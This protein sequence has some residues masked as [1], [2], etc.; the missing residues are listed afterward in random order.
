MWLF[1]LAE[2]ALARGDLITARRFADEAV[3]TTRG[4]HMTLAYRTRAR[5]ALAQRE[6]EQAESDAHAALECAADFEAYLGLA[7]IMECLGRLAAEADNNP[8]AAR[9]LAAADSMRRRNGEVR[10]KAYDADYESTVATLRNALSDEDF[11]SVWAEGAALSTEEAI[12][13]AQRGRG[14]RKRPSTG[15]ASLTPTE[16]DVARLV[17]EGLGNKDIAARLFVSHRT[18]QT[19]LT[20]VYTKLGMTSRVQLAQ[21]AARHDQDGR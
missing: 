20:H 2:V 17:G 7:D 6:V 19:H 13:Y 12:A 4:W 9:L 3:S 8:Q 11:D 15:W 10:F 14:K 18:V 1:P 16:L 21:E 5:V